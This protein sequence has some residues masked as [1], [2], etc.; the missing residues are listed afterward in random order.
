[1]ILEE[2]KNKPQR[3]SFVKAYREWTL[4]SEDKEH[5]IR[6]YAYWDAE[7]TIY[8]EERQ[9][10]C[11]NGEIQWILIGYFLRVNGAP[12]TFQDSRICK[13]DLVEWITS[14]RKKRKK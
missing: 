7:A 11:G 8:A 13:T 4:E 5:G 12:G 10:T 9:V 3:E 2:L 14:R 1:M 6:F